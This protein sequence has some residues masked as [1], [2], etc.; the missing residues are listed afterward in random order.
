M[1][2][3]RRSIHLGNQFIHLGNQFI[4]LGNQ[5]I[6][7]GKSDRQ[8]LLAAFFLLGLIRLGLL[9]LPFQT[10]QKLLVRISK[11]IY[12]TD[13]NYHNGIGDRVS[14]KSISQ[15]ILGVNRSSRYMPGK[16]KCLARALTT[17]V[18]MSQHGY[19]PQLR[20]GVAKGKSDRLEAHAWVEEQ[21]KVVIGYLQDL[22]RFTPMSS[23]EER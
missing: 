22:A 4:Y 9:L 16:V 5:Y 1:R 18:L 15:I 13:L 8:L 14:P 10:L 21:G 6:H 7:L 20:I 11:P 3:L 19:S 23:I 2:K 17:Q 12:Q